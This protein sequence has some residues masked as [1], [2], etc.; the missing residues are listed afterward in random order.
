MRFFLGSHRP[1]WL[2]EID[3]ALF[4]SD[5]QLRRYKKLPRACGPWALD[6]G[7]F[8][9]L[10]A[11]G[12]WARGPTPADYAERVR[13]YAEEIGGLVFAAPQDWMCEPAILHGG[14][15]AAMSFAG[16]GL[17]V[18]EHQQR[19]VE[20][21]LELH[22]LAPDLPFIPV[23]QGWSTSD[24]LRCVALYA[25]NGVDL[26][27]EPTVGLG[28]VCR[29]QATHEAAEIIATVADAVPG[30]RIHGFGIKTSGLGAYGSLLD[31]ADSMAWSFR[32]RRSPALP[33]CSHRTCANCR[34]FAMRWR[35]HVL[36]SLEHH[37]GRSTGIQMPLFNPT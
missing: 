34:R 24:Y 2:A 7:G 32:A 30:I 26:A 31:S 6:S 14:Q 18:R 8:T 10:S 16:T 13:R 15:F 9:E 36:E 35:A 27:A 19:T 4:V 12:S 17:T 33:G 3:I 5:R 23:L 22:D 29:R 28:S 21:F 20:N 37:H 1:H 11:H 25:D